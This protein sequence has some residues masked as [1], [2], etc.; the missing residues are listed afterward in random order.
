MGN[1]ARN[2]AMKFLAVAVVC[3]AVV[4]SGFETDETVSPLEEMNFLEMGKGGTTQTKLAAKESEAAANKAK[5]NASAASAAT[6][7][8]KQKAKAASAQGAKKTADDDKK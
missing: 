8:A 4:V 1:P 3:I 5:E 7:A 2:R 6:A